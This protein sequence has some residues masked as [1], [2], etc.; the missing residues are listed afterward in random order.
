M[1]MIVRIHTL[2]LPAATM[3]KM[4]KM[5][6]IKWTSKLWRNVFIILSLNEKKNKNIFTFFSFIEELFQMISGSIRLIWFEWQW[7]KISILEK[8]I[9]SFVIF[10]YFRYFSKFLIDFDWIFI[11]KDENNIPI[12]H[13]ER[14]LDGFLCWNKSFHSNYSKF[15]NVY[16]KTFLAKLFCCFFLCFKSNFGNDLLKTDF[17]ISAFAHRKEFKYKI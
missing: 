12:S 15:F 17:Q 11:S 13:N 16:E 8:I 4:I 2:G 3:H 6:E 14:H 1:C 9:H 10:Y 5:L 7:D